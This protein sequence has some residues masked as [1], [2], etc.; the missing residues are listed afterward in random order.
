MDRN[1]L[2]ASILLTKTFSKT[3]AHNADLDLLVN[4]KNPFTFSKK[5]ES[6][7]HSH[8]SKQPKLSNTTPYI[9]LL[10]LCLDGIFE[11]IALGLQTSLATVIFIASAL[12]INKTVVAYSVGV[13]IK[14]SD[15]D[16]DL[17]IRL[18]L[19]F[20]LICPFGIVIGYLCCS[21]LLLSGILLSFSTGTFIY[22]ACSVVIVE[23]FTITKFKYLKYFCY[24]IGACLTGGIVVLETML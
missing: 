10:A 9:L 19:F 18:I 6:N 24:L 7:P 22:V 13:S 4:P 5:K 15:T 14:N 3:K 23:E 1:Q 8:D 11:G 17:F 16:I 20:S 21:N 2:K 12:I